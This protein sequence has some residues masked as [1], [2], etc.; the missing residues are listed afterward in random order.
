MSSHSYTVAVVKDSFLNGAPWNLTAAEERRFGD[1]GWYDEEG[2]HRT[3]PQHWNYTEN[4]SVIQQNASSYARMNVSAC[5]ELYNDYWIPQGNVILLVANETVQ[6]PTDDSLLMYVGVIPRSD[7]WAKNMWA[8][9][10]GTSEFRARP[11]PLPVTE[12]L[13]GL[14]KYEVSRCL[15][16]PPEQLRSQC[17]FQYSPYIM[18]TVCM[19]NMIKAD[20]MLSIWVMRRSHFK[21]RDPRRQILYTLGDAISSFMRTPDLHTQDQCLA[22]KDD[23][24]THR[25][26]KFNKLDAIDVKADHPRKMSKE[27]LRWWRAASPRRW[28]IL[29]AA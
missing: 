16:Q 28:F 20:I 8:L 19:M 3:N 29:L 9:G 17:R 1:P 6:E 26:W 22:T 14:P 11:P 2:F 7:N 12:W 21:Q 13:V 24:R 25:D 10:N 5:F 18:F 27:T 4:I 23:Y 15:V